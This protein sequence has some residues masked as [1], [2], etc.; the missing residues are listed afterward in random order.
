M[1]NVLTFPVIVKESLKLNKYLTKYLIKFKKRNN[2]TN[3][4]NDT[5]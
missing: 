2:K 1:F 5:L 4:Q 3:Q